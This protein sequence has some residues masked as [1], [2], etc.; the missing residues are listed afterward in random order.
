M[1]A[2]EGGGLAAADTG[3]LGPRSFGHAGDL[4]TGRV[5]AGIGV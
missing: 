2:Y 4:A 5:R 1:P 3:D